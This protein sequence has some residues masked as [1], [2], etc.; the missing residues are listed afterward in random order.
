MKT[1]QWT[2]KVLFVLKGM[3]DVKE[4]RRKKHGSKDLSGFSPIQS[5]W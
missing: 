5:D 2:V 1:E 3:Y 4:L